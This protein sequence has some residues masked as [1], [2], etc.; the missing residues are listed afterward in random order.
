[1]KNFQKVAPQI[2]KHSQGITALKRLSFI[3]SYLAIPA[4]IGIY[5]FS[6]EAQVS[7]VKELPSAYK[8]K[9]G[10]STQT[11]KEDFLKSLPGFQNLTVDMA[12][13][14]EDEKLFF[15]EI[16]YVK[17]GSKKI[18][19]PEKEEG[20]SLFHEILPSSNA[21]GV[22]AVLL[23]RDFEA[24]SQ[25]SG[26]EDA[27]SFENSF[28]KDLAKKEHDKLKEYA[29][30][31]LHVMALSE[32]QT[33]IHLRNLLDPLLAKKNGVQEFLSDN[34]NSGV[35][36]RQQ[37]LKAFKNAT[38]FATHKVLKG[39][40]WNEKGVFQQPE[41]EWGA[42]AKAPQEAVVYKNPVSFFDL[43]SVE[44][45]ESIYLFFYADDSG[46]WQIIGGPDPIGDRDDIVAIF[47]IQAEEFKEKMN[48]QKALSFR[49]SDGEL[50]ILLV[51]ENSN[52]LNLGPFQFHWVADQAQGSNKFLKL[53]IEKLKQKESNKKLILRE[54]LK[55]PSKGFKHF[56]IFELG[57]ILGKENQADI[58]LLI[59]E[60]FLE[61]GDNPR[62]QSV[63][64]AKYFL[65]SDQGQKATNEV[66]EFA[67]KIIKKFSK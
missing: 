34:L 8:L 28:A 45:T 52:S 4:A 59:L 21:L 58:Q 9:E 10:F 61:K 29:Y 67:Q 27:E 33:P 57:E 54:L 2:S 12:K 36:A 65:D 43:N 42:G 49:N 13:Y 47:K 32:S 39:P 22:R 20:V 7:P 31:T 51:L 17:G 14:L 35:A 25:E 6:V 48:S 1:M 64:E 15:F 3:F 19:G 44:K 63:L 56:H 26:M 60:I 16:D 55:F 5:N 46:D 37:L 62:N 38:G 24:N 18:G 40:F 50:D 11:S 23:R 53:S 41:E 66:R 30:D